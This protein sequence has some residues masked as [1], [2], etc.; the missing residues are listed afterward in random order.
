MTLGLKRKDLGWESLQSLS[1]LSP[2][3]SLVGSR[4]PGRKR[5]RARS[6]RGPGAAGGGPGEASCQGSQD[7]QQF[8]W[9]VSLPGHLLVTS[10]GC[11]GDR[12]VALSS[13]S[14]RSLWPALELGLM[15]P[16]GWAP[17]PGQRGGWADSGCGVR[18]PGGKGT[19]N[20]LASFLAPRKPA[21]KTEMK[22][23]GSGTPR[24]EAP[25]G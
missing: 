10:Q 8:L 24:K 20:F 14:H 22:E 12:Q 19:H 15:H 21:V 17:L 7:A 13:D 4:V 6:G 3:L 9:C 1:G 18:L 2:D 11:A 23:E 16:P 25:K 5:F